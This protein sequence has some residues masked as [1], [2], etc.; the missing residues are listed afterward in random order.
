MPTYAVTRKSDGAEVY[1]YSA[2]APIEWADMSYDEHDH[3]AIFEPTADAQPAPVVV[4]SRLEYLR[5]FTPTERIAIR[6]A[7]SSSHVLTDYMHLLD[8][9]EVVN[10]DHPDTVAAVLMLENAGLIAPGRAAEI[11]WGA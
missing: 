9:A 3:V 10:N 1:R 5:R 2:D 4:W 11:L 8:M 7:A 6:D